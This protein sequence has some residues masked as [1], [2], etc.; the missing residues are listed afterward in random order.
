MS[1][2]K[3]E[4]AKNEH[5]S[6]LQPGMI[7]KFLVFDMGGKRYAVPLRMVKEVM[8]IV[9]VTALPQVQSFYKGMINLRGQIISV[10]DLRVKLGLKNV[11]FDEKKTAVVVAFVGDITVGFI[12]D[13]VLEV[14]S[15][16]GSKLD[17]SHSERMHRIDDGVYG[18]AKDE[19]GLTLLIDLTLALENTGFK[20]FQEDAV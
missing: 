16:D 19:E 15:Y 18:V 11:A 20:V 8:G 6:T 1:E 10:V 12:V 13:E 5:V 14:V 7:T 9:E 2:Q 3:E 17:L 4:V